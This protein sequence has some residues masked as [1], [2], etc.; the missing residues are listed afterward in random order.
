MLNKIM[1]DVSRLQ[2][3]LQQYYWRNPGNNLFPPLYSRAAAHHL[4]YTA[5]INPLIYV[6]IPPRSSVVKCRP[7]SAFPRLQFAFFAFFRLFFVPSSLPFV[8]MESILLRQRRLY[9]SVF[10]LFCLFAGPLQT[11]SSPPPSFVR[12]KDRA[13]KGCRRR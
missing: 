8:E 12:P 3:I 2:F 6:H 7:H 4:L 11:P 9:A 5:Y 10:L 1:E 13:R